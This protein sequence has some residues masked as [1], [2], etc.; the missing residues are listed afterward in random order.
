MGRIYDVS[1]SERC[2]AYRAPGGG[3]AGGGI[4]VDGEPVPKGVGYAIEPG[5][6]IR[7]GISEFWVLE[8]AILHQRSPLAEIACLQ[9]C[10]NT[11]E[12]PNRVREL[13]V[14]DLNCNSALHRCNDWVSLVAVVL[15]SRNEPDEPP[16]AD[17]IE[18]RDERG[19][20]LCRYEAYTFDEQEAFDVQA[21]LSHV[22]LGRTL[23][24]RLSAE[25]AL[26]APVLRSLEESDSKLEEIYRERAEALTAF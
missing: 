8:R 1:S 26:L 14:P 7:F 11:L 13:Q 25:P 19:K 16:C 18:V 9:A 15:E 17:A 12:D 22:N 3:H 4:T 20:P 21:I 23:R 24:L 6:V 10:A 5:S 2:G